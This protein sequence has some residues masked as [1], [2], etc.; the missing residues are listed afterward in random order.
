MPHVRHADPRLGAVLASA[1]LL[2]LG[3]MPL[4]SA[5]RPAGAGALAFAF[6]LSV[7]QAAFSLPLLAREW[8]SGERGVFGA[9]SPER[10][11]TAGAGSAT[12]A[13]TVLITVGTGVLFAL[14]TWAYVLAFDTAGT[15]EAALALQAY[16]LFAAGSETMLGKRRRSRTELALIA[17]I[18]VTLY[19]LATGGTWRPAGLSPWFAVALAVPALWSVAHIVL[20]EVLI[21]TSITPNQVTTSRLVVS[22]LVLG[23]LALAV[24]GPTALRTTLG[25]PGV[26]AAGAL[27]GLAYYLEL[28]LWFNAMRHIDVSLASTITVPA[29]AVTALLGAVL[30]GRPVYAYQLVSLTL[31]IIGL[32]GLLLPVIAGRGA[33]GDAR[34]APA[35]GQHAP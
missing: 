28:V 32:L 1:C 29:P 14:S 13:R 24:E 4:I 31:I 26:P 7:W 21:T 10:P 12:P 9:A 34:R 5:G 11:A 25:N 18:V 8:W 33:G 19:H 16:P 23:P 27:L 15:T 3:A 22:V 20:R 2:L 6:L 17:L 30:L 35:G